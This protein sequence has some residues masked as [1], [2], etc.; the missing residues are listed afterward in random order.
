MPLSY[1]GFGRHFY[2][3]F[4]LVT[5]LFFAA[6]ALADSGG[7]VSFDTGVAFSTNFS[8]GGVAFLARRLQLPVRHFWAVAVWVHLEL[9]HFCTAADSIVD[10]ADKTISAIMRNLVGF[11]RCGLRVEIVIIVFG[12]ISN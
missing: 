1:A 10:T 2:E 8:F 3:E 12:P 4:N 7:S 5:A 6:W 9:R 11:I